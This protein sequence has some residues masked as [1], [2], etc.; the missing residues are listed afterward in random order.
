MDVKGA[1]L[2]GILKEKVYMRQPEGYED[3][4]GRICELIKTIYG[5][6]QS[7]REW[8]KE[9]DEKLKKFGFQRLR[10]DPCVYIKQDGNNLVIIT[11]WVDDLLLFATSDELMQQT[12]SDLCTEWEITDLGEPTKIIGI[13]IT[14]AEDS[15]T[16]SQK[17]YIESILKREGLSEINSVTTPLDPNIKLEPNPDGSEGNR[18]NSFARLLGELQFLANN[19]RPDISFAVN[20]LAAYTANPSLQHVTT[21]KRILR[22]LAGT[23]NLGIT[24][25]KNLNENSNIFHG[26]ADAAFANHDDL[27]STS[28]YVFSAAGGAI[29]WKS[30]KQTTIALSSTEAEYV[31]LSEA[32]RE[33]CWL[34]NLFEE[35]GYP[36]EFPTL[37]KGDNDGSISMAKNHQFHNRSK[38]IA[39]RWHWVRELV[40]HGLITI[41]NCRDPQQTADI[42]TKALPRPK[43]KRHTSEMGLAS[44]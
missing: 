5:L 32:G 24:Y 14:Q 39:I 27:K 12:K 29:T 34:R 35:L 13:E 44:T 25:S 42:L 10:S 33:A 4:T 26:F 20:R 18:S 8:N 19:T 23:K 1:Y 36:Q 41:E 40:E 6:K 2:N 3:K 17:V 31:A 7:G 38:H 43:H 9:L 30:K 15:I 37:I 21:L 11:V 28:G 16:I 22:Y